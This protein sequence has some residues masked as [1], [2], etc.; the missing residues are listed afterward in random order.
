[1]PALQDVHKELIQLLSGIE[2]IDAAFEARLIL[3]Q[4][5][6]IAWSDLIASGDLALSEDEYKTILNVIEERKAGKPLS[7]I[8]GCQEF[9]GM[10]LAV[11]EHVLDPR[12]DSEVLIEKALEIF[13]GHPPQNILDLGTGSG[14]LILAL[15]KEWPQSRAV[16]VDQS[17]EA[18]T[19]A[20]QNAE[21]HGLQERIRFVRSS[22]LEAVEE[23]SFDLI[24]SNPP[25]IRS[26]VIPTLSPEVQN[27]DP[28]LALDGGEDGLKCYKD[29]FSQINH[30]IKKPVRML[31]EIGFDQGEDVMRLSEESRFTVNG[32]YHDLAG[33]PRVVDISSGDK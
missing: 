8:L 18:L 28:I 22:W 31:F 33:N 9:W 4:K 30:R 5:A 2:G 14:C 10:T 27:H 1:M 26:D 24:V 21:N 20:Q 11:N 19:I 25:Y 16:A 6:G 13:R 15:L 29:I 3:Q 23:D 12:P 17:P 32:L 7:K